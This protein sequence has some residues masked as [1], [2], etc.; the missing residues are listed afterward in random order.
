[1]IQKLA[2][3]NTG[4]KIHSFWLHFFDNFQKIKYLF[5][6][7]AGWNVKSIKMHVNYKALYG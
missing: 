7:M 5:S 4:I 2:F 6:E 3:T 1:M